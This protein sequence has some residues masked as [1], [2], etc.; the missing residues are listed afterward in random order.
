MPWHFLPLLRKSLPSARQ[1]L[2]I[3]GELYGLTIGREGW[4]GSCYAIGKGRQDASP[5]TKNQKTHAMKMQMIQQTE[6]PSIKELI[7]LENEQIRAAS[8]ERDIQ[9]AEKEAEKLG[10]EAGS[11]AAQ[12]FAQD[13]WGG[14]VTRGEKEAAQAFLDALN[15]GGELPESPNLSGEW[16]DSET[17]ASLMESLFG[18]DWQDTPEYV[19]AQDEMCQAWEDSASE[20]FFSELARSAES[21][22][23]D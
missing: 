22:L 19:E 16:A 5:E 12:W 7:E 14:R 17:P 9:L 23:Q 6:R 18:Y 4:H 11:N 10:I 20:A 15:D 21:V 3:G 2:P 8:I 1:G 13:A